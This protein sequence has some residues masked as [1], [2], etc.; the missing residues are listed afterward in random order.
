V[1][2]GLLAVLGSAYVLI[3]NEYAW[4]FDVKAKP[5]SK[6][7][8]NRDNFMAKILFP[9]KYRMKLV[10]SS[11]EFSNKINTIMQQKKHSRINWLTKR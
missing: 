1:V 11:Y 8:A 6:A 4:A 9:E 5:A 2:L 10:E 7:A 3:G